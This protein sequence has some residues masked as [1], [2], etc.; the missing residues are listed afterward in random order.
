MIDSTVINHKGDERTCVPGL[1][2]VCCIYL[3]HLTF[4]FSPFIYSA[5]AL[6]AIMSLGLFF[7]GVV[8]VIRPM[9]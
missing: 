7:S 2:K 6:P 3:A 9:R 8:S 1:G 4:F 5:E